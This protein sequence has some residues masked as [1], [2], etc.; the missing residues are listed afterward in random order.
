M[1]AAQIIPGQSRKE[2]DATDAPNFSAIKW[3]EYSPAHVQTALDYLDNHEY[4]NNPEPVSAEWRMPHWAAVNHTLPSI[5][6]Q[7]CVS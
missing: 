7:K 5:Q 4:W 1:D 2:Y 3:F 6:P